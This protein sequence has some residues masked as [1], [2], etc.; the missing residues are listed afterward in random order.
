M[1]PE[2][3]TQNQIEKYRQ[4]TGEQRLLIGLN[5]HELSCEIA[6]DGIRGRYPDADE[7]FVEEKLRQRLRLVYEAEDRGESNQ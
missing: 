7:A 1:S 5:L 6:R 3:F 2:A 4:M